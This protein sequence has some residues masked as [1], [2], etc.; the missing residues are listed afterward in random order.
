MFAL[1]LGYFITKQ[2]VG[3]REILGAVVIVIGLALFTVFGDPAGGRTN[4]PTNE[5]V[6]AIAIVGAASAA[7]LYFGSR[8]G[9][10]MKAGVYGTVAGAMY[11]LAAVLTKP[12]L[13]AWHESPEPEPVPSTS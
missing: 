3:R 2:Y 5:W 6:I 4:A 10:S 13:T 8:G 7:G 9:L 1:P 11:G 12:V